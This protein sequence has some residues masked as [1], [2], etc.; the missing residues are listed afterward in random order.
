MLGIDEWDRYRPPNSGSGNFLKYDAISVL[1]LLDR[2]DKPLTLLNQIKNAL[3]PDGLLII[4]I[5]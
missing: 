3:K 4:G 2:C 1:N 5:I